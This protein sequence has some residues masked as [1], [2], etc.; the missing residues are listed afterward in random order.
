MTLLRSF[1]V[2]AAASLLPVLCSAQSASGNTVPASN[3]TPAQSVAAANQAAPAPPASIQVQANLVLV[4]VVVSSDGAAVSGLTKDKFQI[5]ENG[6]PQQI[7]VFDEHKPENPTAVVKLPDL[8]PHTY[9]DFPQFAVTSAVNV[10]LLDALNT[11][12][13]DQA[14]V[15]QQMLQYLKNIPPGTRIAVFTLASRLR[16]VEGFTTDSSVIAR[17]LSGKG[18]PQ[19]SVLLDPASDQ[20]LSDMASDMASLGASQDAMSSMQ[21]FLADL[22]SFQTDLRVQMTLDAMKDLARYLSVIPGRKNLIWFSGSFPLAIDPDAT[23]QSPFSAMRTYA[24]DVRQTDDMLSS[25]RVAVYPVDARGLMSLPSTSAAN[26]FSSASSG[27]SG[28]MGGAGGR[29]SRGIRMPSGSSGGGSNQSA[30]AKADQKFLQQ[31]VVEH[32]TMKEIA[33]DTGGEAFMDNNGL[34]G[35][36]AQAIANGSH[37]YTIGYV[38]PLKKYDGSFHR[39][40]LSVDGGYQAAYR[41]GYYADDPAKAPI[42]PQAVQNAINVA[43]Q[44]GAPPLSQILFK[45]R[46]LSVDDP[47]ARGVKVSPDPAGST[48]ASLKGLVKRYLVDYAVD[49]HPLAFTATPDGVRHARLE[50]AV[51]AYDADGKRL[52]YA[53]RGGEYNLTPELYDRVLRTGVPMHQEIDLP[54]GLVFLRIVVHDLDSTLIGST[55]VP[56]TVPK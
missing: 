51:I 54:A 11:P 27:G 29:G 56:L 35:A 44:R 36:V 10:L 22:A 5:L 24:E 47:A 2:I 21:Q 37:Y 13:S 18:G 19:Q 14:Y 12:L 20:E 26:R 49:V 6:N 38:P 4:D 40:K 3:S 55:E 33:E 25:A 28:G 53:D 50:F 43:V 34:K 7:T 45:V 46:V 8:P 15:R 31:T 17:A 30:A 23:L 52:N 41:R 1:A 9:S 32:A 42:N 48:V 39:I 16:M